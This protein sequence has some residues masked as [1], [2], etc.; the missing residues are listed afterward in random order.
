MKGFRGIAFRVWV[1]AVVGQV[2]ALLA[3]TNVLNNVRH[4]EAESQLETMVGRVLGQASSR[5]ALGYPLEFQAELQQL[6]D[7][8]VLT[9]RR[10]ADIYILDA[11]GVVIFASEHVRVGAKAP[12]EWLPDT[13][14]EQRWARTTDSAIIYGAEIVNAFSARS[15]MVIARTLRTTLLAEVITAMRLPMT[16]AVAALVLAGILT[17]LGTTLAVRPIAQRIAI[18]EARYRAAAMPCAGDVEWTLRARGHP[19]RPLVTPWMQ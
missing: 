12:Q 15:G 10:G 5:A 11:D 7:E 1:C 18:I 16:A 19:S 3:L 14:K 17:M 8:M 9:A 6:I 13:E 4:H 2:L